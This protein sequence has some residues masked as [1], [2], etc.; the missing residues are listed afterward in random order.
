MDKIPTVYWCLPLCLG[1]E[2][3]LKMC[4]VCIYILGLPHDCEIY[5]QWGGRIR[6]ADPQNLANNPVR[7]LQELP[8]LPTICSEFYRSGIV[9][10]CVLYSSGDLRQAQARNKKKEQGG[11]QSMMF[12]LAKACENKWQDDGLTCARK[13]LLEMFNH[14]AGESVATCSIPCLCCSA[15][16]ARCQCS[17]RHPSDQ[18]ATS[19]PEAEFKKKRGKSSD[20]LLEA[21]FSLR[22]KLVSS[23]V[24]ALSQTLLIGVETGL[25]RRGIEKLVAYYPSVKSRVSGN[26]FLV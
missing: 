6:P 7:P 22:E 9:C 2:T 17:P 5:L 12:R 26:K 1:V 23:P 24:N 20:W 15:C 4:C 3:S 19:D 8:K 14:T 16:L 21:L 13:P 11:T 25:D 18:L 10:V